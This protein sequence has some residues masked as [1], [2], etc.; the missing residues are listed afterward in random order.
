M[1]KFFIGGLVAVVVA[2]VAVVVYMLFFRKKS[3]YTKED[4]SVVNNFVSV[5]MARQDAMNLITSMQMLEKD[6]NDKKAIATIE[7]LQ[8]KYDPR[9]FTMPPGSPPT[10]LGNTFTLSKW[11]ETI[12]FSKNA[13]KV[14]APRLSREDESVVNTFVSAGMARQDAM[15]L[16]IAMKLLEKNGNDKIAISMLEKLMAQ[17]PKPFTMPPGSPPT[18]LGDRFTLTQWIETIIFSRMRDKV[19]SKAASKAA[20]KAGGELVGKVEQRVPAY[21]NEGRIPVDPRRRRM[22]MM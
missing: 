1:N 15:N 5:G 6:G 20:S 9:P 14:T 13:G 11:V 22:G 19:G 18:P 3:M 21:E 4:E 16:I 12:R 2:V 10:P 17:Y 7:K 8:A